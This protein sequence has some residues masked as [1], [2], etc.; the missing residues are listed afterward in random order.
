MNLPNYFL[1]DL[2]PEASLN[3]G[4]IE[5]ACRTLKRNR[6]FY[7]AGRSTPALIRLLSEIAE[8]W[9]QP[10][11]P[12]RK[13]AL[14][15]G[16]AATGFSSATLAAGL[17]AFFRQLT[18]ENLRA[19]VVQEL[20][21]PQRLDTFGATSAELAAH[22]AAFANGPEFPV[23]ITAASIPNPTLISIILGVLVRSAQ[24]VKCARGGTFLPRLF[25]HSLYD[26][27]P[28]LGSCLEIA[29][30]R[31][32]SVHLET[33][34]FNEADCITATGSDETLAEIRRHVPIQARFLGYGHRVS[35]G[36]IAHEALSG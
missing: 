24:F 20:G 27:D 6:E 11:Y 10:D 5:E 30:W 34:L 29:E 3:Q 1:A 16:P 22:R 31:G 36:Y 8:N 9:L 26:A 7:L 15:Q 19:L 18:D 23:H 35:F 32:G 4:M 28:K 13:L 33:T 14:E 25:A 17:D 2:P 21:H 12:F